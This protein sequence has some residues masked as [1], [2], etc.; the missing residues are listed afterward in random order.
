MGTFK[1]LIHFIKKYPF[2]LVLVALVAAGQMM[3]MYVWK[4]DNA[5]FFKFT[6]LAEPAGYLGRGLLGEGPYRLSVAPYWFVYYLFGYS[7]IYPFYILAFLTYF[8]SIFAV[9][10]FGKQFLD[11]K[12]AKVAS[13]LFAAGYVASEGFYWLASSWILSTS[14][15]LTLLALSTSIVYIRN[16]KK[17]YYLFSLISYLLCLL[18]TPVRT[19]YVIGLIIAM[20]LLWGIKE[21]SVKSIFTTFL[22]LMPF[23]ALFYWFFLVSADSRTLSL[24][25]FVTAVFSG[26]W[27]VFY[28]FFST[29]GSMFV[30]DTQWK[31]A[32]LLLKPFVGHSLRT[33]ALTTLVTIISS[34]FLFKRSKARFRLPVFLVFFVLSIILFFVSNSIVVAPQIGKGA[35]DLF[36]VY[37]GGFTLLFF[38]FFA[39]TQEVSHRKNTLFALVWFVLSLFV[40][41]AYIP[42]STYATID[43]YLGHTF[44]ALVLLYS[45]LATQTKQKIFIVVICLWGLTNIVSSFKNQQSVVTNKSVPAAHFFTSLK[46]QMPQIIKGNLIYIDVAPVAQER[47][48]AAFSVGQMP[49]TTA[50]AWR[51]GLDRY[52]FELTTSGQYVSEKLADKSMNV[53]QINSFYYDG[54]KLLNTT[55]A[56][57]RKEATHPVNF[58]KTGESTFAV[59]PPLPTVRDLHIEV[60][61]NAKP[62][63]IPQDRFPLIGKKTP[64]QYRD[65]AFRNAAFKYRKFK[66]DFLKPTSA[67]SSSQWQERVIASLVDQNTD[68]VWQPDRILW[69]DGKQSFTLDLGSVQQ[70]N[71]LVWINGFDNNTPIEYKI[72]TS[73]D[74]VSYTEVKHVNSIRKLTGG[75]LQE[76]KF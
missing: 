75:A 30:T 47:F 7:S 8:T 70:I 61:I 60:V 43:R 18:I 4:D 25:D 26:N 13:F 66:K 68:T 28:S 27:Y 22:K 40:Y 46:S 57:R 15:T 3:A 21:R 76:E 53:S 32:L 2:F 1:K 50:L 23:L 17:K 48:A 58:I 65:E 62:L 73:A 44:I 24:S 14:I 33:F 37:F 64:T 59:N 45:I 41:T 11:E 71:R 29:S 35:A 20:Y 55:D 38:T 9:Y 39:F 19:H 72:Y 5:I 74:N 54:T 56:F 49:E 12:A 63:V 42:T 36:F 69:H 52:D 67:F 34:V 10:L 16:G 51:Y 31:V 6:H